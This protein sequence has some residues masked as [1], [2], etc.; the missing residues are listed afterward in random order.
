L[1]DLYQVSVQALIL[2]LEELR[3]LPTGTWDRLES[4]GFKVRRAQRML[5]I[6]AN[7]PI[8]CPLPARYADLAVLAYDKQKISE[9][10][11]ARFLRLDRV[12]ARAVLEAAGR[13]FNAERENDF[14]SIS[15]DLAAPLGG[16]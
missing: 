11:L 12:S 8:E 3:R 9:G 16:K 15:L 5:G 2:R 7:P 14:A 4:E 10:Q 1:A 13:R 6:E